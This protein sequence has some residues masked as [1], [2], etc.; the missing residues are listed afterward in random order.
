MA[1]VR[2][3]ATLELAGAPPQTRFF[4]GPVTVTYAWDV[5][6]GRVSDGPRLLT[7]VFPGLPASF[8]NGIDAAV[9]ESGDKALLFKDDRYCRVDLRARTSEAERSILTDF[10]LP[11][12]Y[13]DSALAGR[14]AYAGKT[15]FFHGPRYF[16]V[17]ANGV[18]EPRIRD[19]EGGW[20]LPAPF[21]SGI[22][23]ATNGFLIGTNSAAFFRF[24]R[25]ISYD[26]VNDR[27]N[28]A[29]LRIV[30]GWPGV[31]EMLQAGLATVEALTWVRAARAALGTSGTPTDATTLA[32][33]AA[34]FKAGAVAQLATIR[35]SFET[36]ERLLLAMPERY[37]FR[38]LDEAVTDGGVGGDNPAAPRPARDRVVPAYQSGGVVSFTPVFVGQL[39]K[40]QAAMVIHEMLHTF[41]GLSGSASTHISEWY[42]TADTFF[43]PGIFATTYTAQPTQHAIH[44]P[45]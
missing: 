24:D 4:R 12:A 8:H 13:V 9:I 32:A 7:Q 43:T 25:Y 28:S 16:K 2:I 18:E 27:T 45:S 29:A 37:R 40:A 21:S 30:D 33:L 20:H 3:D 23:A 36:I 22:D 44:N 31:A 6:G 42:T 15:Y 1:V 19:I 5:T 26:W 39:P 41:D 35:R 14:G 10:G 34:H 38:D 17:G 11:S